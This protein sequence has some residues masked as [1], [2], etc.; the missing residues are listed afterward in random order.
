MTTAYTGIFLKANAAQ[1]HFLLRAEK[2]TSA[3]ATH[4]F[5]SKISETEEREQ[6]IE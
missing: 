6:G 2:F 1:E 3:S 4:A 5:V